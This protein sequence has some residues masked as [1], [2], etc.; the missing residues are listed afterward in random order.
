MSDLFC[1]SKDLT[2]PTDR[3]TPTSLQEK[4]HKLIDLSQKRI[5][6]QKYATNLQGFQTRQDQI[7][8]AVG[9]ILPLVLALRAFR[10]RG[11]VNSLNQKVDPF[12]AFIATA[13][14][15][16]RE[17]PEWIIDNNNFKGNVFNSS[18][19]KLKSTLKQ[20]LSQAWK[21][22]LTQNIPNINKE[23]L[24]VFAGVESLKPTIQRIYILNGQIQ[25]VEFPINSEEFNRVDGLIDQL[26]QLLDSL[27]SDKIPEDVQKFL[28]AAANQGATIDLLTPEVKEW[29]I[30]YR[31][32][33]SLRIRLT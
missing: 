6:L 5:A 12:L 4:C 33:E 2:L 16:F 18:V 3:G 20:H 21:N 15:K 8:K 9:E 31:I 26:R 30:K 25:Q 28:K 10:Q 24:D 32:A 29:L 1:P 19:D 11:I 7:T 14:D 13:E 17:N 22:Y 23:M 27:N